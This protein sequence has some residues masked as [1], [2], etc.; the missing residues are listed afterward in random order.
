M[1]LCQRLIGMSCVREFRSILNSRG[2]FCRRRR[3]GVAAVEFA[4][5]TPV[6]MMMILGL[7][8]LGYMM[9][10]AQVV[11]NSSREGARAAALPGATV[12]DVITA[13]E[14]TLDAARISQRTIT[15]TPDPLSDVQQGDQVSVTV[16]VQYE[17]VSLLPSQW[18]PV[19][20]LSRISVMRKER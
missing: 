20:N 17:D 2:C 7:I 1:Y 8:E 12:E 11:T 16:S 18:Q 10:V 9:M 6:L 3:S 15:V 19:D 13:A 14:A 4:L 5:V